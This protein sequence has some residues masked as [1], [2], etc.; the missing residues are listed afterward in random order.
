MNYRDAKVK[1][2]AAALTIED[3]TTIARLRA[4]GT[5]VLLRLKMEAKDHGLVPSANVVGELRGRTAPHEVVVIGGHLDSWDV[6]QGAHDDATGVVAAMEALT[7]LRKLK[8]RPR[9]T[10]RVVL[11]TNEENGL[12]GGKQYAIDHKSELKDHVAAIESDSGCFALRGFSLDL[13]DNTRAAVVSQ[14]LAALAQLTAP[15]GGSQVTHGWGGADIIAL[16]EAGVPAIGLKTDV[17]TYFNIHHT[18]ADTLEKVDP[19]ELNKCVAGMAVMAY[20]LAD[21]PGRLGDT[22]K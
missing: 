10:I 1:I 4:R 3:A 5:K 11:W 7:I 15:V 17:S 21:M 12:R 6:G 2:P 20:V 16:R 13:K 9:R 18:A 22:V 8:L 19:V 14:E